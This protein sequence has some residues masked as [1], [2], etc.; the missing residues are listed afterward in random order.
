MS[1]C[2]QLKIYPIAL[3]WYFAINWRWASAADGRG[4]R[5]F[6]SLPRL[7][8]TGSLK[9]PD[10]HKGHGISDGLRSVSK[11]LLCPFWFGEGVWNQG[12]SRRNDDALNFFVV[13]V[14]S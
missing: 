13:Y 14:A 3:S 10:N 6:S 2:R 5:T 9:T 7:Q 1:F 11:N 4:Q 8:Y 12:T